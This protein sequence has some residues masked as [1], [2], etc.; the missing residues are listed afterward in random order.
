VGVLFTF[1]PFILSMEPSARAKAARSQHDISKIGLGDFI[2]EPFA[3]ESAWDQMVLIIKDWD[4][5]IYSYLI[6]SKEGKTV[7]PDRWWGWGYYN[8]NKFGP[9]IGGNHKI[10]QSGFIKCHDKNVPDWR[11]EDWKWSYDGQ[12]QRSWMGDMYSPGH[13]VKG[14]YLYINR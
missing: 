14:R 10:K 13:E 12:S 3:R 7:M 4:G 9:E 6:L 2:F 11:K 8:C 1:M 5:T